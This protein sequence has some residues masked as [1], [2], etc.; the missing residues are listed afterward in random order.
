MT[1]EAWVALAGVLVSGI[2]ALLSRRDARR[3]ERSANDTRALAE[4]QTVAQ[5]RM[6][7]IAEE[8]LAAVQATGALPPGTPDVAFELDYYDGDTWLL[9]NVG[10]MEATGVRLEGAPPVSRNVPTGISIGPLRSH[11]ILMVGT[12][13][14]P[15]PHEVIVS[16]DQLPDPVAL[17]VP[18]KP[19]RH[20]G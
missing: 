11:K 6:A 8:R 19:R 5:E 15:V 3:A 20:L 14:G 4:R 2:F 18:A 12:E 17:Q 7:A 9:R 13:G 16:A 10:T 1:G